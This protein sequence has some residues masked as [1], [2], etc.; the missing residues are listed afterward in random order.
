VHRH[1][2]ELA[3]HVVIIG[4]R[5][6]SQDLAQCG[7]GLDLGKLCAQHVVL[8]LQHLQRDLEQVALAD[9]AR[10]VPR[11]ADVH[12]LLEALQILLGE[13]AGGL[14]E[15]RGDKLLPDVEGKRAFVV[16]DGGARGRGH[17]PGGPQAMLALPADLE[18]VAKTEIELRL[19]VKVIGGELIRLKNGEELSV[20]G[21]HGIGTE[22]G[23]G[24]ERLRFENRGARRCER[25]VVFERETK[26][27]VEGDAERRGCPRGWP[28]RP[29]GG[30]RRVLLGRP[31]LLRA[32]ATW[33]G[34]HR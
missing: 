15:N 3:F 4:N 19:A 23:G 34:Q 25:M 10:F 11:F 26:R 24:F 21:K 31:A 32:K 28:G 30:S 5:L 18:G 12:G 13:I 8:E 33:Q 27:L 16:G 1:I 22:I 9:G 2:F 6:E 14:G 20:P 29:R 17:V 7:E